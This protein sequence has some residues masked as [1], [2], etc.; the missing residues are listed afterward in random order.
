MKRQPNLASKLTSLTGNTQE[1]FAKRLNLIVRFT[2]MGDICH[3]HSNFL[4]L[5]SIRFHQHHIRHHQGYCYAKD[6]FGKHWWLCQDHE[7]G[8]HYKPS[9][10][11]GSSWQKPP[12]NPPRPVNDSQAGAILQWACLP[13]NVRKEG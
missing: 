4:S 9:F 6:I 8:P 2:V 10:L 13:V 3:F 11:I 1:M 5:D 12:P 7:A